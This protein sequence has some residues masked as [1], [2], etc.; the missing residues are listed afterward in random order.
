MRWM[1]FAAALTIASTG[2][3]ASVYKWVDAQGVTHFDAQPPTGQ[4]AQQINVQQPPPVAAPPPPADDGAA[5]QRAIDQKVKNQI[6]MQEAKRAGNCETLRTNLAQLQNNPRV[7][8]Q[9]GGESRRLT[10][11]TRKT[12]IEETERAISELCR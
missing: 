8:E 7:R 11:E 9:V 4:Q 10:E 2:Q 3:A 5:Q 1:I 6:K 12:R